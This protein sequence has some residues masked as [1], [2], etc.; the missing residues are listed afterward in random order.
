M[1]S[2]LCVSSCHKYEGYFSCDPEV[3]EWAYQNLTEINKMSYEGIAQLSSMEYQRASYRALYPSLKTK[4]WEERLADILEMNW[5]KAEREHL[6]LLLEL[7]NENGSN[8]FDGRANAKSDIEREAIINDFEIKTY[9]WK[10]YAKDVLGWDENIL[11]A[12][13]ATPAKIFDTKGTLVI[14]DNKMSYASIIKTRSENPGSGVMECECSQ[15]SDWCLGNTSCVDEPCVEIPV[16][17]LPDGC[18]TLLYYKCD[19]MCR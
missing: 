7:I 14:S 18:G 1:F 10:E 17:F 11:Y 4:F 6:T 5:N 13:L 9:R 12:V 3:N 16:G 15:R 19:G 2:V 8:W